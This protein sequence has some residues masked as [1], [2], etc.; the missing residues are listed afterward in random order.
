[1]RAE[2]KGFGGPLDSMT[3]HLR[4]GVTFVPQEYIDLGFTH[5]EVWCVGGA[6]GRGGVYHTLISSDPADNYIRKYGGGGGGGGMQVVKG[7]LSFLPIEVPVVVGVAGADAL[8]TSSFGSLAH[9]GDGGY[10]SFNGTTCR[11]SGGGGGRKPTSSSEFDGGGTGG[12]GG[13]G[14]QTAVGGGGAGGIASSE[15]A[16]QNGVWNGSI[17][18]G[19]GGGWGGTANNLAGLALNFPTEAS[20]GAV[21]CSAASPLNENAV[22]GTPVEFDEYDNED[23]KDAHPDF[24]GTKPGF[25][26]GGRPISVSGLSLAYGSG[27]SSAYNPNGAVII[28]LTQE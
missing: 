15:T 4:N 9:G 23:Y 3:F 14:G 7:L 20:A 25:G 24:K 21:G 11:A 22:D 5:F 27:G 10:S 13:I 1:M 28:R 16:A 19:G 18:S 12:V 17:G 2:F 6:G 8:E 26:G